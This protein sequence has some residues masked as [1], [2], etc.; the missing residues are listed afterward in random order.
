ML[1]DSFEHAEADI[2]ARLLIE[3]RN[4]AESV[5]TATEKSLRAPELDEIARTEFAPGEQKRI[6]Q[7]LTGL[8][9][10]L[11][12]DDRAAI[13]QWTQVLNDATKHLAELMMNRSVRAA[14][15]GKSVDDV[16]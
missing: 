2:A 1:L 15:A 8:K 13:Q 16:R 10:V 14:L 11:G 4:E 6:E 3:A 9:H 12:S 7:A 5:V